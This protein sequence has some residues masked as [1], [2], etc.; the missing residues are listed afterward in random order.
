MKPVDPGWLRQAIAE[1]V[2]AARERARG[3]KP[4]AA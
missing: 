2:A 1:T 3:I 4:S